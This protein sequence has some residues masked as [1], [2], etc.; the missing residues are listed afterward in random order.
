MIGSVGLAHSTAHRSP[1]PLDIFQCL[2]RL[3]LN[4]K[5]VYLNDL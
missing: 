2:E 5:N 1:G 3:T 4:G